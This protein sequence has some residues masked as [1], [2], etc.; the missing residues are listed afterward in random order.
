MEAVCYY[1]GLYD[2]KKDLDESR[3]F[4]LLAAEKGSVD[5]Y[6]LLALIYE[7]KGDRKKAASLYREAVRLGRCDC[8]LYLGDIYKSDGMTDEAVRLYEEAAAD[9][10][11]GAFERIARY[12][13]Y[14]T[15]DMKKAMVWYEKGA[16]IGD[17]SCMFHY[18]IALIRGM[19]FLKQDKKKGMEYLKKAADM[20]NVSACLEYATQLYREDKGNYRIVLKYLHIAEKDS[21]IAREMSEKIKREHKM[22]D[23]KKFWE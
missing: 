17:D 19:Y 5:A 11:P 21:C 13:E 16:L 2:Y 7:K 8:L 12:H 4:A 1:Y 20:D 9:N 23:G 14:H 3:R 22:Q 15:K 18:G 10:V 6:A